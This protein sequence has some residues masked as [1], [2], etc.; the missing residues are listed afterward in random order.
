MT[1]PA[2]QS[3]TGSSKDSKAVPARG[4]GAII[5]NATVLMHP[6]SKARWTHILPAY[7][8]ECQKTT[9]PCVNCCKTDRFQVAQSLCSIDDIFITSLPTC[10]VMTVKQT[11]HTLL[12]C[13]SCSD[14]NPSIKSQLY[15]VS[16]FMAAFSPF[17][18]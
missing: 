1:E 8:V 10:F 14:E 12:A 3:M 5:P 11:S 4:H 7:S 17:F 13:Q 2:R 16:V 18:A 6:K 9:V 15:G